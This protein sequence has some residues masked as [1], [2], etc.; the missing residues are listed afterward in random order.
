MT[1]K[2]YFFSSFAQIFF[3]FFFVLL[4]IASVVLLIDIAGR[5]YVVKMS[6]GDLF[7]FFLYLIPTSLFFIIPITFFAALVLGISRL[8]YEYELMVCFSLG[9][10]PL[11]LIRFFMPIVLLATV[12]LLLFSLVLLP[13]SQSASK[14]FIAQKKADI[15][16][17][18]KPGE[19]GQKLGDWLVYVD[20]AQ[21]RS[22]EG[23]IL[24]S[25][26]GFEGDT[27]IVADSGQTRNNQGLFE[28]HL[29]QGSAY[30]ANPSELKRVDY[31]QMVVR[32]NVG[33][34][35]IR[36]YDLFEYWQ[37]AFDF[38]AKQKPRKL[39]QAILVSLFPLAS[40]FLIPLI[41]IANPRFR[42]N[43]SYFYV[44]GAVALYFVLTHIASEQFP[45]QGMVIIPPL[46]ALGGY[47]LYRKFIAKYY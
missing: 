39:A 14:N 24:F 26:N 28:L 12:V 27:F 41:G 18:I 2:R 17:N 20:K 6:F 42:T 37:G 31:Q 19:F 47:V 46:W 13:L 43:M 35:Q 15:D 16:V 21:N 34:P 40:V 9:A 29:G 38:N 23:L 36:G 45:L 7:A 3:P 32:Q 25:E 44:I 22:Y 10:K 8:A 30:F 11:D 33:E 5:T 4:F 1:I